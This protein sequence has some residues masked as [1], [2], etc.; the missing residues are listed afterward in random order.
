[1]WK[2]LVVWSD[3]EEFDLRGRWTRWYFWWITDAMLVLLLKM[4]SMGLWMMC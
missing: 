2:E 3:L 4:G 1:M